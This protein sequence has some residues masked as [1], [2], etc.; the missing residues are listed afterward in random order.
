M[1]M[2]ND[3]PYC[4]NIAKKKFILYIY[5]NHAAVNSFISKSILQMNEIFSRKEHFRKKC[6]LYIGLLLF[7]LLKSIYNNKIIT[8][9]D[10]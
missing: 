4:S 1:L 5:K 3:T 7:S 8:N 6:F 2:D 10:S 9:I